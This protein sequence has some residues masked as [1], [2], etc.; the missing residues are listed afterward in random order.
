MSENLRFAIAIALSLLVF[1]VWNHFFPQNIYQPEEEEVVTEKISDDFLSPEDKSVMIK[2]EFDETYR[3]N[4][5]TKKLYGSVSLKG[6]EIDDISLK[7]YKES[8]KKESENVVLLSPSNTE[9]VYFLR[10][11]FATEDEAVQMPDQNTVWKCSSSAIGEEKNVI[12]SWTNNQGIT[13]KVSLYLDE[14]YLFNIEHLVENNGEKDVKI[15][16]YTIVTRTYIPP[17]DKTSKNNGSVGVFAG[18]LEE[19]SFEDIE[20]SAKSR[21]ADWIGFTDKYWLTAL[22][23]SDKK[24]FTRMRKF[25]ISDQDRY[26]I[27]FFS[28][29]VLVKSKKSTSIMKSRAFVGAKKV[30]ILDEYKEKFG[31]KLFDRTIDFGMLYFLTKGMSSLLHVFHELI[32]NF[33][34]AILLLTLFIKSLLFPLAYKSFKSMNRLKELQPQMETLKERLKDDSQ[35]LQK[36]MLQ[37]YKKEKVNPLSGCLPVLLQM[38]VFFALYRVLSINIE[39]RHAPFVLFVKDLSA[40]DPTN[41]FNLFGLLPIDPFFHLGILPI[42]MALTMLLQQS[43][44]PTPQD[45]TQAQVMRFLPLFFL[46]LFASFPAGLIIYWTFSNLLSILQQI[47]IKY[48]SKR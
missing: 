14:G 37:L 27:D 6:L 13:F 16:P 24:A 3:I 34:F 29:A 42:L 22:I 10:F 2:E 20:N 25:N 18:K 19:I 1:F 11:G 39:M 5:S 38:P 15:T 46:V 41:I 32:G 21:E 44:N 36:S 12:F 43:L 40:S 48:L 23:S 45:K 26:Q 8:V 31:I 7:G 33:G 47:A 4:L 30:N 17:K 35:G 28:K 9:N